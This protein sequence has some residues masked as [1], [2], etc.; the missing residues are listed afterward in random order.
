MTKNQLKWIVKNQ[1]ILNEQISI[2]KTIRKK[3]MNQ[4]SMTKNQSSTIKN[5]SS[6][7]KNQS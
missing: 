7:I 6:T 1:L 2:N 4:S 3:L 5:Q